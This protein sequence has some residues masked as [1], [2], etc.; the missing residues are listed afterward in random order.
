MSDRKVCYSDTINGMSVDVEDYFQVSNFERQFPRERWAECQL[1]VEQNTL[2]VLDLFDRHQVKATFFVLGWVA[3]RLPDIVREISRRGHEVASHGYYHQLVYNLTP[4]SFADDITRTKDLLESLSGQTVIGYRAPSYTITKK[5]FWA[6]SVLRN[7][8]YRY[9]SSIFPIHHHRYGIPDFAR[10]PL[11]VQLDDGG[12]IR[13]FPISTVRMFGKNVPVGGGAYIR[14]FPLR[15]MMAGLR[16]INKVENQPFIFYFHPWEIDPGQPKVAC[17]RL[18]RIRH[19]GNLHKM[20]RK[21][22]TILE[23]FQFKPIKDL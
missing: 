20:E 5:N 12:S 15:L 4:E 13:E 23:N 16:R 19:Y 14:L 18:T 11:D 2:R 21:L 9:D 22:D 10:F 3:E 6:L 7:C 1:R 17:S 8:G